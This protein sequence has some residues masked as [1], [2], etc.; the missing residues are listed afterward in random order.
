M[1]GATRDAATPTERAWRRW[2]KQARHYDREMRFWERLL[3][4]LAALQ[5]DSL[6]RE[7][8][9]YLRVG[10]FSIEV[11]ERSKWSIVE[12]VRARKAG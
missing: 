12:R 8:L 7:P 9:E 11:V 5:G 2:D 10:G 3:E 1:R 4:P 6:L